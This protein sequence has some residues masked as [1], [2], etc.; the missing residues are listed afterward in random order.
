MQG[1]RLALGAVI[2]FQILLY[3]VYFLYHPCSSCCHCCF[4]PGDVLDFNYL[5]E[6]VFLH[7]REAF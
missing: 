6:R 7:L 3:P 2:V 4:G 1:E 5:Q